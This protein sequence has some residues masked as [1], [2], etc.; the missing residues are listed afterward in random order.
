MS[1]LNASVDLSLSLQDPLKQR[2]KET[3]SLLDDENV[4]VSN[5]ADTNESDDQQEV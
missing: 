3:S 5:N 1:A 2:K 4:N